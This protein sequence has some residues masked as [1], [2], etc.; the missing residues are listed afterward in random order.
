MPCLLLP[1]AVPVGAADDLMY[2]EPCRQA[3]QALSAA[4][5][6]RAASGPMREVRQ[7]AATLCLG[8]GAVVAASAPQARSAA[9]VP[10]LRVDRLQ[11][12]PATRSALQLLPTV[13]VRP[14][15]GPRTVT[16]CD[17]AGCWASDGSR[18][19]QQGPLL[20]GPR[21]VCTQTAGVLNCP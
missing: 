21:G 6:S 13:P 10:L 5:V 3:L 8:P 9:P 2:S 7:R 14:P 19:Q 11:P 16:T 12:L 15:V 1:L 18:L 20:V 17:A 4:E